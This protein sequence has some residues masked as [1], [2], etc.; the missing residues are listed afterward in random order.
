MTQEQKSQ[1]YSNLLS[2]HTRLDNKINEIKAEDFEL[3]DEQMGRIR[4]L[5]MQ[6]GQ[7]VAQMQQLMNG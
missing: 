3:N 2:Q 1:L 4:T 6:Q 7:L 5:Q